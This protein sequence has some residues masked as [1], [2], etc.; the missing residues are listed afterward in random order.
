MFC[1]ADFLHIALS[2]NAGSC[3]SSHT[4]AITPAGNIRQLSDHRMLRDFD[5]FETLRNIEC[6]L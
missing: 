5:L 1:I 4:R 6:R 2:G 3:T